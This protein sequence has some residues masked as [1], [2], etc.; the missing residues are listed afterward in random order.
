[1]HNK[2]QLLYLP[3]KETKLHTVALSKFYLDKKKRWSL[4]LK[5]PRPR[6]KR[7]IHRNERLVALVRASVHITNTQHTREAKEMLSEPI[8]HWFGRL[9]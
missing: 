7:F 9:G 1:M 8:A 3:L 4:F 2:S 6:S 5:R